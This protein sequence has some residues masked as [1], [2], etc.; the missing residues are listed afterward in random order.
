MGARR[1]STKSLPQADL[2]VVPVRFLAGRRAGV[3]GE[4]E[5]GL[6]LHF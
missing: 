5:G 4:P 1:E 2:G 3:G 6:Q